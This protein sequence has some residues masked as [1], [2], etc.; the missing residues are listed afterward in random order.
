MMRRLRTLTDHVTELA[1]RIGAEP[2]RVAIPYEPPN[3][4]AGAVHFGTAQPVEL[5]P[6]H[7]DAVERGVELPLG[8]VPHKEE[9]R[10]TRLRATATWSPPEIKGEP[11]WSE[12]LPA[13]HFHSFHLGQIGNTG[14]GERVRVTAID[15]EGMRVHFEPLAEQMPTRRELVKQKQ[16]Q[17]RG[18]LDPS[19]RRLQLVAAERKANK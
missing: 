12:P 4:P 11:Y 6:A 17:R 13:E 19:L 14:D 5:K 3:L 7:P 1:A 16:K 8:F 2:E 10:S 18:K 9:N 15:P